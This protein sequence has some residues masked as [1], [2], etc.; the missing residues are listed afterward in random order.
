ML[1][2]REPR[3]LSS[4]SG[5]FVDANKI[6]L[7][8][9]VVLSPIHAEARFSRSCWRPYFLLPHLSSL[10]DQRT[11][12]VQKIAR[13]TTPAIPNAS[14]WAAKDEKS[15]II[16]LNMAILPPLYRHVP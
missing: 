14:G 5:G 16:G 10:R 3:S 13:I 8:V 9:L 11:M 4:R 15:G 6:P 7:L 1:C 2:A 12:A